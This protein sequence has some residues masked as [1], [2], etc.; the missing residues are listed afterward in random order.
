MALSNKEIPIDL[1]EHIAKNILP[2][3]EA[4]DKAHRLD[5]VE[6]VMEESMKLAQY[7]EVETAMVYAIAADHDLG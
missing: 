2:R 4:F 5:H 6:K 1:R 3:Y 7:Y